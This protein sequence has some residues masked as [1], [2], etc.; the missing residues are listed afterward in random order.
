VSDGEVFE[1]FPELLRH[2]GVAVPLRGLYPGPVGLAG[3]RLVPQLQERGAQPSP[4]VP[5]IVGDLE[6]MA[7]RDDPLL[8]PA[9]LQ[10]LE[11]QPEPE[12]GVVRASGEHRTE[13]VDSGG[14][15]LARG[16]SGNWKEVT[17][18]SFGGSPVITST[19]AF[20]SR[21]IS[22]SRPR[23]AYAWAKSK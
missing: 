5:L 8:G 19:I 18:S 23:T 11:G 20:I 7:E 21:P 10:L 17:I 1:N 4:G 15:A 14:H 12:A 13:G 22:R 2:G 9:V 16:H 3:A 6:V